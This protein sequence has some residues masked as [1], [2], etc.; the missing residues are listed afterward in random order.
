LQKR[1]H[2]LQ[3]DELTLTAQKPAKAIV[4]EKLAQIPTRFGRLLYL[5]RC[6]EGG[7]YEHYGMLLSHG[8]AA[9]QT[10]L[11]KAHRNEWQ[12]WLNL[13]LAGQRDDLTE[14]LQG[15]NSRMAVKRWSELDPWPTLYPVDSTKEEQE[16]F[17]ADFRHVLRSF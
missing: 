3:N 1:N 4:A 10:V 11:S 9:V 2:L 12:E 5:A 6:I 17:A 16:L 8:T 15:S 14:F 13:P 7:R